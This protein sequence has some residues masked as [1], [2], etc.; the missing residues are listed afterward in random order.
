LAITLAYYN[1]AKVTGVKSF[2]V[3]ARGEMTTFIFNFILFCFI[4]RLKTNVSVKI[5]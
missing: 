2:K 5:K 1:T 4:S 3:L